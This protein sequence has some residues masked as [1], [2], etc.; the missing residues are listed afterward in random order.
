VALAN[1]YEQRDYPFHSYDANTH[2][3]T[4][5]PLSFQVQNKALYLLKFGSAIIIYGFS[6]DQLNY[7]SGEPKNLLFSIGQLKLILSKG[8]RLKD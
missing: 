8:E 6:K 7:C 4:H 3:C 5:I 1:N 2:I